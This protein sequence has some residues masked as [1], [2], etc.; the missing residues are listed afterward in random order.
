MSAPA[1]PHIESG[2][3]PGFEGV[4]DAFTENFAR[5]H[6]LGGACCMCGDGEK[7]VDL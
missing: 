4:R 3:S 7:V 2:V 1:T 6:E 5:R